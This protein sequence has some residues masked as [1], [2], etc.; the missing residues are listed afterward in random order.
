MASDPITELNHLLDGKNAGP[1]LIRLKVKLPLF[2]PWR[3]ET[4]CDWPHVMLPSI[5]RLFYKLLQRIGTWAVGVRESYKPHDYRA[6]YLLYCWNRLVSPVG[7][8][9]WSHAIRP[10]DCPSH[11]LP[12]HTIHRLIFQ[13]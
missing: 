8:P 11:F 2:P 4:W 5:T 1:P 9:R 7:L 3:G 10:P 6:D 12:V 13:G